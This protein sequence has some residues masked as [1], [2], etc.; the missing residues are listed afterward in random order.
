MII[1]DDL[2][3]LIML[4]SDPETFLKIYTTKKIVLN[5][6]FLEEYSKNIKK[7]KKN[8]I[9]YINFRRYF[10]LEKSLKRNTAFG[11]EALDNS[12]IDRIG[13]IYAFGYCSG[14]ILREGF[15]NIYIANNGKAKE[16]GN[17]RIGNRNHKH[18]YVPLGKGEG[19]VAMYKEG[20]IVYSDIELNDIFETISKQ[21]DLINKLTTRIEYLEKIAEI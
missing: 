12:V 1:C 9:K 2:L 10:Y 19:K 14:V 17:I 16:S 21:N 3:R 13:D 15:N 20:E 11:S 8:G 6:T 5:N 7:H 18:F 4:K